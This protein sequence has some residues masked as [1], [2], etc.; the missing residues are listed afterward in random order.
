MNNKTLNCFDYTILTV[1]TKLLVT[2]D[3][4]EAVVE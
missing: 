2:V 3:S 4:V 1:V